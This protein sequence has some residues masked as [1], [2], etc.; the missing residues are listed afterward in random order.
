MT[1]RITKEGDPPPEAELNARY[2]KCQ[3]K[4]KNTRHELTILLLIAALAII[5]PL[6]IIFF[7][8]PAG[9]VLP[10]TNSSANTAAAPMPHGVTFWWIMAWVALVLL[11]SA[12][13]YKL[14]EYNLCRPMGIFINERNVM[15]LS[16]MQIIA[17][18]LVIVSA[19][20]VMVFV[21]LIYGEPDPFGIMIDWHIWAVLGLSASAAV[22]APL[23]NSTKSQT[24]PAGTDEKTLNQA[25]AE[26]DRANNDLKK[27]EN[28]ADSA[29]KNKSE[30]IQNL[31][32]EIKAASI[33]ARNKQTEAE[34]LAL[35]P[36][37]VNDIAKTLKKSPAEVEK[38][39]DGLLYGNTDPYEAR[40]TDIFEGDE[41]E[42]ATYIDISKVQM[43]WFSVI[44]IG[45]YTIL[46]MNMFYANSPINLDSFPAFSD[47]FV[48][49]LA[50]S[51]ATYLGGK[52]VTKTKPE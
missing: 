35:Y 28:E 34:N 12:F 8:H 52:S 14:G 5:V 39:R 24:E 18:T 45:G 29:R 11:I 50:V 2:R 33:E 3:E 30:N 4:R 37:A 25:E 10:L 42:N 32:N 7:T 16:R 15:S 1:P 43:F 20:L 9:A 21:R 47:G 40:F 36:Q 48:A 23:I 51:H 41:L 38:S 19:L 26:K 31:D 27:K 22:G 46:V 17:W 13:I 44:A 49:I 6:L